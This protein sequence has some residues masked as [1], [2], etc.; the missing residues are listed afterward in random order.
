MY[1]WVFLTS[2]QIMIHFPLMNINFPS[3]ANY[4]FKLMK[5]IVNIDIF[6]SRASLEASLDFGD[7]KPYNMLFDSLDIFQ[8]AFNLLDIICT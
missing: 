1:I 2:L 6:E 8:K 7:E 4:V 5:S 3:N